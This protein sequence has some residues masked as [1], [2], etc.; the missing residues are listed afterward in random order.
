MKKIFIILLILLM[1]G[2]YNYKELNQISIIS[3]I[4]IDKDDDEY[5][6][7][8]QIM[9]AKE[10]EESE[11]S[12]VIVYTEKGKTINEALRKMTLKAPNNLYGGHL[13][14]LVLSEEVAKEGIINVLD[15]FQRLT[16]VR[17]EFTITVSKG[18]DASDVIK[19]MTAPESVPAE[20][21]TTSL[22]SADIASALTYSTKLDEFV[23]LYLKE[24]ID[25]VIAVV[26]VEDYKK[27][28]TT[29]D[30]TATTDPIS[31]LVLGN[32][33]VTKDGKLERYLTENETIGYNFV[34]NQ[35]QEM[36]IPV[37]CDD[38]NYSSI[39]ILGNETKTD[40]NKINNKYKVNINIK[41]NAIIAEY[42][43]S[44]NLTKEKTIKKLEKATEKKIKY[45]VDKSIN[46]QNETKGKF[47]GIE[48]TIYLDYPEYKNENFDI[49]VNADV[50][51]SR[52]GEIRNSSKGAKK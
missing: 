6:V 40:V 49:S 38:N 9:N 50:N 15:V 29:T 24:Y 27:K 52:K 41:T 1:S 37:K 3:S 17:N 31:K 21:V 22:K 19:V 11:N 7:S 2:C 16:E 26:E 33:A 25:P 20:Y 13:S 43:C 36:I 44:D 45:Y 46:A 48:R 8:A 32:I 18:I 12:Q 51:L 5:K 4:A 47:L 28:G 23:S 34:R 30:N 35:V 39:S 42:N 14:K 10:D